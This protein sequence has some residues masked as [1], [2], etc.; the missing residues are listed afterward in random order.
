VMALIALSYNI[1]YASL[2]YRGDLA[3]A[4]PTGLGANL[5]ATAVAGVLIAVVSP[6][7]SA[8]AGPQ[9]TP[10]LVLAPAAGT[11]ASAS[12]ASAP[13]VVALVVVTTIAV[14][15][16]LWAMGAL[17]LGGL[18][19]YLPYPVVAGFLAG[20]GLVLI[21]SAFDLA[22]GA[23]DAL[24]ASAVLRWAGAI[25]F[26]LALLVIGRRW[27][28]R[29][30]LTPALLVATIAAVHA[31]RLVA[32]IDVADAQDRGLLLG[33]FDA[34]PLWR[35]GD[36]WR[37][38][39]ID[40]GALAGELTTV[41]PVLVLYP[42]ALLLYLGALDQQTGGGAGRGGSADTN[43][44]LRLNGLANL[45]VAPTGASAVGTQMSASIL[46]DR[47]AGA[48]RGV[49]IVAAVLNGAVLFVG[50]ASLSSIPTVLVHG[51]TLFLGLVLVVE[52]LWDAR[53][54]LPEGEYLLVLAMAVITVVFDFFIGV[55]FGILVAVLLFVVRYSRTRSIRHQLTSRERR[56]NVQWGE[57]TAAL[58]EQ[59]GDRSMILELDGF[60]FFGSADRLVEPVVER[61]AADPPLEV[62]VVDFHRVVGID[63]DA[64]TAFDTLLGLA[65]EQEFVVVFS[66][67]APGDRE[68][69]RATRGRDW[70]D[71][72]QF[73]PD[74]DR[75]LEW[76]ETR[77]LGDDADLPAVDLGAW[78][79]GEL[80][81]RHRAE[82]LLALWSRDTATAGSV[83]VRQGESSPGL[84]AVTSGVVSIYLDD[85]EPSP[86]RVAGHAGDTG[87]RHGFRR[88]TL[89]P[90]ALLGE[91]SYYRGGAATATA[92]ADTDVVFHRLTVDAVTR[93]EHDDP[94][95][96][97]SLHRLLGRMLA[98]RVTHSDGLIRAM[99]RPGGG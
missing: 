83:L 99:L 78:M 20:I 90:G 57:Q 53:A 9:D 6:H 52:W 34:G 87:G 61:L 82:R 39:D 74:L 60:L 68:R 98:E 58:L 80:G 51:V 79:A 97:L 81:D 27:P 70:G 10:A 2:I 66:A 50:A 94:E 12:G 65:E 73:E 5:L 85:R 42:V 37:L 67:L 14:G 75:A 26:G 84:I 30:L 4:F 43:R 93:L 89:R 71:Q 41:V 7:R 25:A 24:D 3:D 22:V 33:P 31:A 38:G 32:G 49:P 21:V 18:L 91:I 95:L 28:D 19:R 72:V 96:A 92:V 15:V 40:W 29:T 36:V 11:I 13:T 35:P 54:R 86:D 59:R 88:R 64:V 77:L 47:L 17:G 76:C 56:S 45:L 23:D 62:V 8:L 44:S 48:N 1:V 63:S 69:L 16:T 46:A 55:A